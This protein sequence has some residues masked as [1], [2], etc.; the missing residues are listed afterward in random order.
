MLVDAGADVSI[1]T[2]FGELPEEVPFRIDPIRRLFFYSFLYAH[3]LRISQIAARSGHKD[4]AKLLA[5][6]GAARRQKK[7]KARFGFAEDGDFA[8]AILHFFLM[9]FPVPD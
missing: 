1:R 6:I 3:P 9:G 5:T 7:V 2:N 4:L 8:R